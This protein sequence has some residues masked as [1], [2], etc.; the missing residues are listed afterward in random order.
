MPQSVDIK[1]V[2]IVSFPDEYTPEQIKTAI[3]T[4]ILPQFNQQ[5]TP[6]AQGGEVN[7]P[8]TMVSRAL[9]KAVTQPFTGAADA[10]AQTGQTLSD[11]GQGLGRGGLQLATNATQFGT[12]V[13]QTAGVPIPQEFTQ[14]LERQAANL[15]PKGTFETVGQA[16]PLFA[17]GPGFKTATSV[18]RGLGVGAQTARVGAVPISGAVIGG[19]T[20]ALQPTAEG[21]SRAGNIATYAAGGAVVGPIAQGIARGAQKFLG[22]KAAKQ[23]ADSESFKAKAS[24][25]YKEAEQLGGVLSPQFTDDFLAKAQGLSKQTTAGQLTVGQDELSSLLTRWDSLRGKPISLQAAKE[26]DEG[27]SEIAEKYF[28][29]GRITAEGRKIIEV[30]GAFRDAIESAVPSQVV[31][32]KEGFLALRQARKAWQQAMKIN[33]I[34]RILAR[35]EFTDQPANSIKNGFRT[36]LNNPKRLRGYSKEEIKLMREAASTNVQL[37]TLRT[38]GSRLLGI[39]TTVTG[40]M[41]AAIAAQV[42]GRAARTAGENVRIAKAQKVIQEI[43]EPG[44]LASHRVPTKPVNI[45]VNP[46]VLT[47]A[48]LTE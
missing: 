23:I 38:I 2:G 1:G 17:A 48:A 28:K 40:N 39:G 14:A 27:L 6:A 46:A 44:T 18:L 15:K 5:P 25:L 4:D 9:K 30:Q 42:A 26:I 31:G 33:D 7:P 20:G 41:P 8:G 32:G 13:L 3:E 10:L 47:G 12:D 45:P 22:P 36:L 24:D 21:E 34:E 16:I 29:E 35:A 11:I 19:G 43:A 37:D